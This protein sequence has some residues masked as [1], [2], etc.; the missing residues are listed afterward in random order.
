MNGNTLFFAVVFLVCF[1]V[2]LLQP[3]GYLTELS[4]FLHVLIS[5]F[6]AFLLAS[7]ICLVTWLVI[8]LVKKR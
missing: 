5:A 6:I 7:A 3:R 2:L 1:V 8:F 4:C